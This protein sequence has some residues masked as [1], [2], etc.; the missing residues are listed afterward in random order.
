MDEL[1]KNTLRVRGEALVGRSLC[2]AIPVGGGANSRVY[3]VSDG[4][5]RYAMKLYPSD[6][7]DPRDRLG[8][9]V[10]A[11]QF[12]TRHGARNVPAVIG[13][14]REERIGLFEWLDGTPVGTATDADIAA[15]LELLATLHRLRDAEPRTAFPSAA[16]AC[17]SARE[18]TDQ[19]AQRCL[20]LERPA[21]EHPAL[22]ALLAQEIV[23]AAARARQHAERRYEA[24]DLVFPAEL[25]EEQRS[26]SPSDFGFH[27]AIRRL[28]GSL[29]FL[30]F[31]YFGWDD[32][33][34]PVAD[35]LLHPGMTMTDRQRRA[36]AAGAGAIY[37]AYS[38][39]KLRLHTLFPLYAL[40]WCLILLNEFLPERWARRVAAGVAAD[41]DTVLA[42]QLAKAKAML[43][44][45]TASI[46]RFPYEECHGER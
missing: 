1:F 35:F 11:L 34:K 16:E 32:P 28:D 40:R 42:G 17:L 18:L 23:P 29:A 46:P 12:L 36:F 7:A 39:Y 41:R 9:E 45:A 27:N 30:D 44:V 3:R 2:E 10:A 43:G 4:Q 8:A 19:I 21:A 6:A 31:E 38:G 15:A 14:D 33:V 26:L 20:R 25:P 37:G 5:C 13:V 22:A 24:F